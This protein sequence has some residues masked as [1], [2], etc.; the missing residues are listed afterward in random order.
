MD[1]EQNEVL[2]PEVLD[3]AKKAKRFELV[4]GVSTSA[5]TPALVA[6][7]GELAEKAFWEYFVARI[8]N[9]NTRMAYARQIS[10]FFG[11]CTESGLTLELMRSMLNRRLKAALPSLGI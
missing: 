6:E 10:K 11:W 5:T 8:S 3:D 7:A 4:P 1:D 2:V 9:K